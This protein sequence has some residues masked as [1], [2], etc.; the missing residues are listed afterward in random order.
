ME[1]NVLWC[2]ICQVEDGERLQ[3]E[4]DA[5]VMERACG[6]VLC[7]ECYR[8]HLVHDP[9]VGVYR[10]YTCQDEIDERWD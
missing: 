6:E 1:G 9:S 4:P 2:E 8:E 7:D 3:G 10:C 5:E